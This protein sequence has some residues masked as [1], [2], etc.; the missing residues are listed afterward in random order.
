MNPRARRQDLAALL[1][2]A[3][4]PPGAVQAQCPCM[5]QALYVSVRQTWNVVSL[6]FLGG[7]RRFEHSSIDEANT[8]CECELPSYLEEAIGAGDGTRAALPPANADMA[9]HDRLRL[10][11]SA[12]DKQQCTGESLLTRCRNTSSCYSEDELLLGA[13]SSEDVQEPGRM[14]FVLVVSLARLPDSCCSASLLLVAAARCCVK[15]DGT[16]ART[17]PAGG[18]ATSSDTSSCRKRCRNLGTSPCDSLE[19]EGASRTSCSAWL[20]MTGGSAGRCTGAGGQQNLKLVAARCLC[21]R[22]VPVVAAYCDVG[23]GALRHRSQHAACR[24]DGRALIAL[25]LRWDLV[26]CGQKEYN[27]N[28]N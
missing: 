27:C 3:P 28:R 15:T 11:F 14:G 17:A 22:R 6:Q 5:N 24:L 12:E 16:A 26:P 8:P 1:Q 10:A 7:S 23:A 13:G 25:V 2:A 21:A 9:L 19:M 18:G 20:R 4:P